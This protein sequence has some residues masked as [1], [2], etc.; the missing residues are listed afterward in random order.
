MLILIVFAFLSGIVTI[1]SPCILPVLPIVLSGSVG[2][3]R[4]PYGVITGFI[5]SFSIFTLTLSAIVQLLNIPAN[6]LRYTAVVLI[7]LLGIIML[8]PRFSFVFEKLTSRLNRSTKAPK[9]SSGFKGG[10]AV[11]LSLGLIWTPCVGPIIASVIS[12]A[13]TQSVDG[14][15]VLIILSYSLGTSIPMLAIMI[16]GRKLINRFPSLTKNT[17]KIQ[18]GF[19]VLMILVGLSI[20]FGLDRK[21]QSAILE[22]LPGYGEGLTVF[23]NADFIKKAIDSRNISDDSA[24]MDGSTPVTFNREPEDGV[25]GDYGMAP[26][27]VTRGMWFNS[28]ALTMEDLRGKVV[29]VDFWTYSCINC[30]RTIP[31]LKTWY[32]AYKDDGLVIIGVHS[33]EFAFERDPGNV[34]KALSELGVTWPVVL[35]NEFTQWQAYNNRYWPAKYFID[36]TGKI[37][38]FHFGEGEYETSEMVIRKLLEE[39]GKTNLRETEKKVETQIE[40]RTAET[41]LGYKRTE[42]FTSEVELTQNEYRDYTGSSPLENGEW[43]L[44]GNWAF[45][46][47]YVV[48]NESGYLEL[49][50][51]AKNVFLVI[52]PGEEGGFMEIE[53]D[54]S[55]S[56]DTVDVKNGVLQLQE[57]RLYQLVGLERSGEHILKLKVSGKMRL[58]AFTFG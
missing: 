52:D 10:L 57:S 30:V 3:K 12:L 47:E 20:G 31:Y 1:L 42:G 27:I 16:G 11:G 49:G 39:A 26:E 9:P 18:R 56:A 23:E 32:D 45:T 34:Q 13:I 50:F 33:P 19:G 38:Y 29:I 44:E 41:Y 2:G 54:G 6:T 8:V 17:G 24:M 22:V 28:E 36:A 15:S 4:R 40:S 7:I 21:F 43:T 55:A 48:S 46:K 35:D 5:L 25:L 51:H 14:G 53:V 58:F 37:R